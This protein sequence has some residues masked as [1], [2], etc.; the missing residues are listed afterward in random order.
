MQQAHVRQYSVHAP[1]V[2]GVACVCQSMCPQPQIP[3]QTVW[4]SYRYKLQHRDSLSAHRTSPVLLLSRRLRSK[5]DR[6]SGQLEQGFV[7]AP[8]EVNPGSLLAVGGSAEAGAG[9]ASPEGEAAFCSGC[10]PACRTEKSSFVPSLPWCANLHCLTSAPHHTPYA[11]LSR[12]CLHM[13]QALRCCKGPASKTAPQPERAPAAL[14]ALRGA[15]AVREPALGW[16]PMLARMVRMAA[17]WAALKQRKC[18]SG[19]RA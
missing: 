2:P 14:A 15:A 1:H 16:G 9:P 3:M 4:Y 8:E 7:L 17:A 18:C 19:G 10:L 6:V 12:P 11:A 5:W 13:L